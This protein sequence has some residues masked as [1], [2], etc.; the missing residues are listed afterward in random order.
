MNPSKNLFKKLIFHNLSESSS[1]WIKFVS[2][3]LIRMH[4][5]TFYRIFTQINEKHLGNILTWR[6]ENTLGLISYCIFCLKIYMSNRSSVKK[7]CTKF[8][9]NWSVI[10]EVIEVWI[11]F[12]SH[13]ELKGLS[14]K[15][16]QQSGNRYHNQCLYN[17]YKCLV[18]NFFFYWN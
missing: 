6:N 3:N 7:R 5:N 12:R 4:L 10:F 8:H 15:Y 2:I 1:R 11:F 18:K 16:I 13:R 14:E 9:Q 17:L